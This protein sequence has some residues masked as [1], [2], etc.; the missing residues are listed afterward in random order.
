MKICE[1]FCFHA[2]DGNQQVLMYEASTPKFVPHQETQ[3]TYLPTL[4]T[5]FILE[6][7]RYSDQHN[8]LSVRPSGLFLPQ[9][10]TNFV[11]D[12]GQGS[13]L[14][15]TFSTQQD[16]G[17]HGLAVWLVSILINFPPCSSQDDCTDDME[18]IMQ[19]EDKG[20]GASGTTPVK[21][22]KYSHWVTS[23]SW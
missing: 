12:L 10:A 15:V 2:Y 23:P 9:F 17:H 14:T 18:V 19:Y 11:Y 4:V 20:M 13:R 16:C 21:L 22:L 6:T 1:V 8:S 7:V 5:F 3:A